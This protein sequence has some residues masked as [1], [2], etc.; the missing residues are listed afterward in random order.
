MSDYQKFEVTKS[1]LLR[2]FLEERV[3]NKALKS[4]KKPF[5]VLL[6]SQKPY[7]EETKQLA[8][9]MKKKYEKVENAITDYRIA[10]ADP[11]VDAVWVLTPN[12]MHY[13]M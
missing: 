2:D 3:S 8:E 13:E 12:Y 5:L 1:C 10:L 11:E 6:N 9:D 4:L 7:S